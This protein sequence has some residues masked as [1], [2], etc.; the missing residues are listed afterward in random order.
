MQAYTT[1]VESEVWEVEVE[2]RGGGPG[3]NTV[4]S[5]YYTERTLVSCLFVGGN[6]EGPIAALANFQRV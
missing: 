6:N 2:E 3:G 5:S 1:H 4:T